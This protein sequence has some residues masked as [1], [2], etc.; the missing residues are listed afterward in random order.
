LVVC[1]EVGGVDRKNV[2][3]EIVVAEDRREAAERCHG[4]GRTGNVQP[5]VRHDVRLRKLQEIRGVERETLRL[6]HVPEAK[7]VAVFVDDRV[8]VEDGA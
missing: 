3:I 6:I 4:I 7:A 2:R 1:A 8:G 5:V